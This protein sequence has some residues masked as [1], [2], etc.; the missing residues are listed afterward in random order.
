M[1]EVEVRNEVVRAAK[2]CERVV[3]KLEDGSVLLGM[4]ALPS[5][6]DD[7]SFVVK[8]YG[9]IPYIIVRSVSIFK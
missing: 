4:A 2:Y 8:E 5:G 6:I 3:V 7:K 9:E 1:T